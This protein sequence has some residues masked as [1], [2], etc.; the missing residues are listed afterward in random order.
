MHSL[1]ETINPN[2]TPLM[3]PFQ[4]KSN[5]SVIMKP[6]S[7]GYVSNR[8]A[9]HNE[10]EKMRIQKMSEKIKEFQIILE[11]YNIVILNDMIL[12]L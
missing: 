3:C 8:K 2:I 4:T 6:T 10:V 12:L 11:V 9:A 5:G 1:T 7:P